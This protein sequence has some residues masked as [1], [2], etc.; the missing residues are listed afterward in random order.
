MT[1]PA[2][3]EDNPGG[4]PGQTPAASGKL[5]TKAAG[6]VGLAVA[7]SRV[8]GLVREIVFGALFGAGR[9]MDMFVTAFRVP[10]LLRDLFAE[11]ALS[12]AFIT[13]FSAKIATE[14]EASA[15]RLANKVA[16]LATI[17]MSAVTLLGIYFAPQ[18]IAIMAG[19]F[20]PEQAEMTILLTRILFPFILLVSLA[21]LTMGMLNA[22]DVFG[23]PAL[24]SSFFNLGSILGGVGF[25][26]WMD[27]HFG[28]R[29]LI[30]LSIGALIGGLLQLV[31][32]FPSLHKVGFRF[33]PDFAWRDEGVR[34][35]LLLMGP[36]VI[37][38]S[39]VQVNVMVNTAFATRLGPGAVSS[40]NYAFRLMQLPLGIFGVAVATVTL[41]LVSRLAS[42][43]DHHGFRTTLGRG[44]R[45]AF[46]LTIPCAV[47]LICFGEPIVS[48]LFQRGRFDAEATAQTAIA[49][50]YYALG[51]V[52]YSGIKVLVP[53]FYA[54]DKRNLPMLVSFL[55]I[56]VNYGLNELFTFHLGFGHKGLALSTSLVALSNFGLL[57]WLMRRHTR[58]LETRLMLANL[59]KVALASLPLVAVCL[60]ARRWYFVDLSAMA[61]LPKLAGVFVT[62]GVGMGVFGVAA[63]LLKI[64]EVDEVLRL[65]KRKLGG[66]R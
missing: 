61:F 36:A 47:G 59:G 38:A 22:R 56:A 16:T 44:M 33:R 35:I 8:L 5:S 66:R 39:A 49:L 27:P 42:T 25:G 1:P 57:Y 18:L 15:W 6:V 37:A 3:S 13:T 60:A 64:D 23:I 29:A 46:L 19:G 11:G 4:G 41:P 7:C 43:N 32:Q 21:A 50:Q 58:R 12:T 9:N 45:L 20:A 34:R 17:F 14:G 26:Y 48:L 40:L 2:A 31:V 55:S 10:N 63:A 54:V 30:G 62:I 53:A 65:V 28:P 52:A 24:A 51:L